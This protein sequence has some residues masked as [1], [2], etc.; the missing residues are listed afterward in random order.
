MSYRA[1]KRGINAEMRDERAVLE[2]SGGVVV[3]PLSTSTSAEALSCGLSFRE[4]FPYWLKPHR[5]CDMTVLSF[6]TIYTWRE[7]HCAFLGW[8]S[9]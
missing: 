8:R 5:L 2:D 9:S 6:R 1:T 4:N 3:A 7:G